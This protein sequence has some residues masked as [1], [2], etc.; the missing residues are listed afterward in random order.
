VREAGALVDRV[1]YMGDR[2]DNDIRPVQQAGMHRA[3]LRRSPW[4]TL[5][6]D[7]EVEQ[8]SLFLLDDL[9]SL[10]DKVSAFN[11]DG[12][13]RIREPASGRGKCTDVLVEYRS[14]M[15]SRSTRS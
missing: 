14:R 12:R 9:K 4:G 8:R 2:I 15:E 13:D 10:P 1:L 5:L 3:L 7:A 11:T 6:R